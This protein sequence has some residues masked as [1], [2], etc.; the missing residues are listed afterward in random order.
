MYNY[1]DFFK[2]ED[3]FLTIKNSFRDIQR[4]KEIRLNKNILIKNI[5]EIE[6]ILL[7]LKVDFK[8][9]KNNYNEQLNKSKKRKNYEK[10]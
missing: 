2:M 9:L 7:K 3:D 4:Q 1:K 6:S 5:N 10:K 8:D